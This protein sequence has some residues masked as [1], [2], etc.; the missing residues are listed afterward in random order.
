MISNLKK[1]QNHM[2]LRKARRERTCNL[3][4]ASLQF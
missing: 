1:V 2:K 4:A 3:E